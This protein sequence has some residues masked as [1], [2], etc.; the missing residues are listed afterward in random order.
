MD[1]VPANLALHASEVDVQRQSTWG[2]L[3]KSMIEAK[4]EADRRQ[5]ALLCLHPPARLGTRKHGR[6]HDD[7]LQWIA[8]AARLP[9]ND[10]SPIPR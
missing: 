2:P 1:R 7:S 6:R 10:H 8:V 5:S 9:E 3:L 4:V